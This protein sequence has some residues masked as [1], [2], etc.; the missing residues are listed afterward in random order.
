MHLANCISHHGDDAACILARSRCASC[1]MQQVGLAFSGLVLRSQAARRPMRAAGA[2]MPATAWPWGLTKPAGWQ[3]MLHA[4][5]LPSHD[6]PGTPPRP[7]A[8]PMC[9]LSAWQPGSGSLQA[10]LQPRPDSPALASRAVRPDLA[11]RLV[12]AAGAALIGGGHIGCKL[13]PLPV[14][15]CAPQLSVLKRG[16]GACIR[17]AR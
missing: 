15:P 1:A 5:S 6:G 7:P 11:S 9:Q 17:W 12:L 4:A 10:F 8:P 14:G 13:Q 16:A 3:W 2:L